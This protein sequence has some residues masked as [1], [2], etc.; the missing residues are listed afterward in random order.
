MKVFWKII[1]TGFGSGYSP[2]APGTAG[3]LAG[4][5]MLW[6]LR[7]V[8]PGYFS[9]GW[10]NATGLVWLILLFFF[11]GVK[12]ANELE[13]EW[14]HDPSKIVVDEMVG[15]WI[16][17]LGVP[18]SLLNLALAFLLFRIFDIWKPLG[19]RK[20]ERLP[21]GWG[22][23]MDDVLAGVY[24]CVLLHVYLSFSAIK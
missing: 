14:G 23:M 11:L 18:F 5:L 21:G 1:A 3:A 22:V 4:C 13:S 7:L 17:M 16:A 20:L 6:G 24:S 19:I 10:D 15:V 8:F 9:G 12:S 2:I